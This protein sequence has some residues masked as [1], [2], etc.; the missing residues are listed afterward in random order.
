[1]FYSILQLMFMKEHLR[2]VEKHIQP[3]LTRFT[4]ISLGIGEY[5]KSAL[6][7]LQNVTSRVS[8]MQEVT[9]NVDKKICSLGSFD[10]FSYP[11]PDDSTFRFS[12]KVDVLVNP[13]ECISRDSLN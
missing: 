5:A 4:W 12:S 2:E 7:N 6:S 3:G 10:L 13:N 8:Q 11:Q 9:L 1:M